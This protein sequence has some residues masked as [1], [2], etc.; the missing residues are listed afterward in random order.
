VCQHSWQTFSLWA[1]FR[2]EELWHR[3]N[4]RAQTETGKILSLV[5]PWFLCP[6]GSGQVPLGPGILAEVVV[7]PV[8]SGMS[9]L[10]GD[11]W[12]RINSGH[13]WKLKFQEVNSNHPT[14]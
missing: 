3:V 7:L 13:R 14:N 12:H 9:A 10:L 4:S 1:E 6:D 5:V 11:L 2:Y 8:F